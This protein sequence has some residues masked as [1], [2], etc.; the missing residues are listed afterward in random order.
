M[1]AVPDTKTIFYAPQDVNLRV[2]GAIELNSSFNGITLPSI[3]QYNDPSAQV[4]ITDVRG[5]L[6]KGKLR[7]IMVAYKEFAASPIVAAT[8]VTKA[9]I[10]LWRN[11]AEAAPKVVALQGKTCGVNFIDDCQTCSTSNVNS[12]GTCKDTYGKEPPL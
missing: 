9:K 5:F 2:L 8:K 1:R 7:F 4:A 6:Q 3:I 12:C 11:T 10:K